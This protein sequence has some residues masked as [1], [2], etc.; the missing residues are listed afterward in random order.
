MKFNL[1]SI[2]K[3]IVILFLLIA[4]YYLL[5][6]VPQVSR[7]ENLSKAEQT[8][9]LHRSI[10]IQNRLAYVELIKLSP[11]SPAFEIEKSNLVSDI[12]TTNQKGLNALEKQ[13]EVSGLDKD[14]N[15]R[16]INLAKESKTFYQDQNQLLEKAFATNSYEEGIEILSSDDSIKLITRQTNLIL[17]FQGLLEQ[18]KR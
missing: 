11:E 10:L 3:I 8:T 2:V 18:L 9:S 17:E 15:Q 6:L 1:V 4:G 14:L 13:P 16:Y 7:I 12:Q 5:I